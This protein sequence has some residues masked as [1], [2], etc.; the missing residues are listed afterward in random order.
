MRFNMTIEAYGGIRMKTLKCDLCEET[1]DGETFED[2]MTA[3]RPHYMA[4]HADVMSNPSHGK[5]E[6][7]QWMADN[8]ARFD[9]A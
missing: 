7:E 1:A 2:W 3:L 5:A 8:K 6:M 4:A 9:A